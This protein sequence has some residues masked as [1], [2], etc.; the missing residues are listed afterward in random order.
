MIVEPSPDVAQVLKSPVG[1]ISLSF[2]VSCARLVSRYNYTSH[3]CLCQLKAWTRPSFTGD[4]AK[5][6][7][8]FTPSRNLIVFLVTMPPYFICWME[9]C[10]SGAAPVCWVWLWQSADWQV[11]QRVTGKASRSRSN[12]KVGGWRRIVTLLP[13]EPPLNECVG[14]MRP[15]GSYITDW[16]E[17]WGS[18]GRAIKGAMK[19]GIFFS[20]ALYLFISHGCVSWTIA[21]LQ[22][23]MLDYEYLALR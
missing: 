21:P 17:G 5:L 7:P 16:R 2:L 1:A 18:E 22:P 20:I 23:K 10:V 6:C 11:R 15:D 13:R 9:N 19:K 14:G 3:C 8:T 4:C 12:R